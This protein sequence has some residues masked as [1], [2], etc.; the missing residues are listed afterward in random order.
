MTLLQL[1]R[2]SDVDRGF[3]HVESRGLRFG[4][5][6]L[7][8]THHV[9]SKGKVGTFSGSARVVE[10]RL[11]GSGRT[12]EQMLNRIAMLNIPNR[13]AHLLYILNMTMTSPLCVSTFCFG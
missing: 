5:L 2:D 11:A 6:R 9:E 12:A 13:L 8:W 4:S 1:T 7:D 10:R 3:G